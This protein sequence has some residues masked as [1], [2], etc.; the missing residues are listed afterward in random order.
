M[1]HAKDIA[2]K[3]GSRPDTQ[4]KSAL[5]DHVARTKALE[6]AARGENPPEASTTHTPAYVDDLATIQDPAFN[7]RQHSNAGAHLRDMFK[8]GDAG[9]TP[10]PPG[11][12]EGAGEALKKLIDSD[13]PHTHATGLRLYSAIEAHNLNAAQAQDKAARLDAGEATDIH[14]L[15][16]MKMP[17]V[18]GVDPREE[19]EGGDPN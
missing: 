4:P 12:R 8:A 10:L 3:Q 2:R 7:A 16:H 5:P 6:L 11:L 19:G 15:G 13:N 14:E 18:G 17:G 1:E 9:F